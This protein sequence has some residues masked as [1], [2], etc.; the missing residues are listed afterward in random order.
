MEVVLL[1]VR[2]LRFKAFERLGE[3]LPSSSHGNLGEVRHN[4]FGRANQ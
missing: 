2:E 3:I 4:G 1:I